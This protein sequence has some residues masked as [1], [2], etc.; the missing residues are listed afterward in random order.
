[1]VLSFDASKVEIHVGEG[2]YHDRLWQTRCLQAF[3]RHREV[4]DLS[5]GKRNVS[6]FYII[7]YEATNFRPPL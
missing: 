7:I 6:L 5:S 3:H 2:Q 4:I 1:V